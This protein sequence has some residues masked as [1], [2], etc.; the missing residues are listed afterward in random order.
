TGHG[1]DG[2]PLHLSAW[3]KEQLGWLKPAVLDPTVPQKLVLSPIEN[4]PK[5]CYKVLIQPDGGEYLLLES[6]MARGFDR[7]LPGEG[8]L[9]WR[10]VDGRPILEESHGISG[11]DG[12][13]RFLS[14]VPY[15]SKSNN[16]F[17]PYTIPSSRPTKGSGL[18]V[19]LTN[20]RRLPDGRIT[21]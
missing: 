16:A 12:P 1:R 10:V 20:I 21:F 18:P 14:S 7:D 11:P 13:R 15:P 6:R 17:T 3:C 19:H 8:L 9:I 2:K 5:E 4:S